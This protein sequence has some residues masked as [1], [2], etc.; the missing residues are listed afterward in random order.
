MVN[1][2][3]GCCAKNSAPEMPMAKATGIPM[4]IRTTKA[5]ATISM[6]ASPRPALFPEQA[7]VP[8]RLAKLQDRSD[9]KEP[10][11]D[12]Q[13]HRDPGIADFG[14]ALKAAR[15]ADVGQQDSR[16]DE[17]DQERRDDQVIAVGERTLHL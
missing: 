4:S 3:S 10:A 11:P 5:I 14:N 2:S 13:A 7:V 9:Q 15:P 16:V 1:G 17:V 6:K 12:R 8:H